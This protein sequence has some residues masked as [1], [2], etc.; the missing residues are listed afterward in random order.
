MASSHRNSS[1]PVPPLG[2]PFN[3][4]SCFSEPMAYPP[5]A[6]RRSR[7]VH[8]RGHSS[9]RSP[10]STIQPAR[11]V[12]P[13]PGPSIVPMDN[14]P[15]WE[16]APTTNPNTN[17]AANRPTSS[18]RSQSKPRQSKNTNEQLAEVLGQLA[19]TLNT[20]SR[21]TKACI[22]DTFS[23][24]EP[25]KLNN[26]LFQC[27]LY[28]H[29]NLAQFDIDIAKINFE[30]T[31]LT[32]VAQ[33]W[34]E[35]GLNQEDQGIL[36]DWLSDWN[37]FVDELRQHFG[38]SDPIGEAA[39]MLDNLRMKPGNK[40][41]T[42]NVDFMRYTS[43]LGWGNSILCHRY[44]Q[45]LPN[46]IQDPI[47]T[48]EQG[49]PTSFQDMY[50]LAMTINH[51]YWERDR[52]RY[53]ARQAEKEALKSHS[54]KQGKASTSSSVTA[55]QNKANPSPAAL[56]TKNTSSKPSPSP[57]PKKQPNTP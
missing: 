24:T 11:T 37:L 43:Q 47:S 20:N 23:G 28:F 4:I 45:G 53:H 10:S 3:T 2:T 21:G 1:T 32:G 52:E 13:V 42:Y 50:A 48:Q 6:L 17:L 31:Y 25:D 16:D 40:I 29:A 26:F 38:L 34:F 39:N 35:M 14:D 30:M 27:R 44:Y 12:L 5:N 33:D 18:T 49:K 55:S 9:P 57:T 15:N 7:R 56:S 36:Q 54:R 41:S 22:P 19:N 46:R 8:Q 51:R